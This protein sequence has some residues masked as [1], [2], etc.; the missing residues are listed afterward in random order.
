MAFFFN[1]SNCSHK[2]AIRTALYMTR[3][4]PLVAGAQTSNM[5][6]RRKRKRLEV[7]IATKN[8]QKSTSAAIAHMN[9]L[10]DEALKETFPASD[11]IA[12]NVELESP[13]YGIATTLGSANRSVGRAR[14]RGGGR[15]KVVTARLERGSDA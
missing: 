6:R 9:D 13:E 1:A 15:G 12:I 3:T 10:L 2:N 5:L 7:M 4:S 8:P 14:R 11:P